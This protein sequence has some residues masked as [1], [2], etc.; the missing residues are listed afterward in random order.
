M[1]LFKAKDSLFLKPAE[2]KS[3]SIPNDKKAS[4]L[5]FKRLC[6]F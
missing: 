6:V 4:V 2:D 1:C 5:K 3:A